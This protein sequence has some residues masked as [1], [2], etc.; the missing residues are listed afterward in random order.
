M[1]TI[2]MVIVILALI[3]AIFNAYIHIPIIGYLYFTYIF[4][5]KVGNK[6]KILQVL[7]HLLMKKCNKHAIYIIYYIHMINEGL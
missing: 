3:T 5:L 4:E 7:K 6:R 2:P 1:Q